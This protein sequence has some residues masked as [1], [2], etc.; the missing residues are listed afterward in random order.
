MPTVAVNPPKTPVTKGSSGLAAATVPNVCKMPGPPAPFVST[1]LPNI[2]KSGDSP[3]DVKIEGKNVQLLADPMM[4]NCGPSGSPANA[5]TLMGLGQG[6]ARTP[7]ADKPSK[8]DCNKAQKLLKQPFRLSE[9]L[10]KKIPEA[11]K[12]L[13]RSKIEA[14][15]ITSGDL[16]GSI[17]NDF[18]PKLK[19]L[20]LY[21]VIERCK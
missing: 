15:T 7:G 10:G 16:P 11:R 6:S 21:E 17:Q 8:D 18:P 13:L 2:G 4:N 12:A 1:P 19:G 20:P 9:K 14:G 5:A 3:D